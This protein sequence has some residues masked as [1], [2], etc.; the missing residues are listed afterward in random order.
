[1][2]GAVLYNDIGAIGFQ[3]NTVVPIVNNPIG[4]GEERRIY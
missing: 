4:E 2:E 1:M 3:G